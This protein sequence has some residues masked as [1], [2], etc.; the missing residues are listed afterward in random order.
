MR[1]LK[2]SI[3]KFICLL[4][5]VLIICCGVAGIVYTIGNLG[6]TNTI[7][8]IGAIVFIKVGS[9]MLKSINLKF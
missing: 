4:T 6:A 8:L 9:V 3:K 5:I 2:N 7:I 1:N